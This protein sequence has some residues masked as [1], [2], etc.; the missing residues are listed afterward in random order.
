MQS[1]FVYFDSIAQNFVN[2]SLA[3]NLNLD[4]SIFN[5]KEPSFFQR[6]SIVPLS[7]LK[8]SNRV[9]WVQWFQAF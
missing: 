3:F 6:F 4:V 8:A 5:K 7:Y 9:L 2:K 1:R